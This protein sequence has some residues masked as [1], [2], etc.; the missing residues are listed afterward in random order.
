MHSYKSDHSK[1]YSGFKMAESWIQTTQFLNQWEI[2]A[3]LKENNKLLKYRHLWNIHAHS[4][5]R[6][7]TH[8]LTSLSVRLRL[9]KAIFRLRL[10]PQWQEQHFWG[11]WS[12]RANHS[13][14]KEKQVLALTPSP[15]FGDTLSCAQG[16]VL[17]RHVFHR[18]WSSA[19]L[20]TG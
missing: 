8:T 3:V 5:S 20:E 2:W 7:H 19:A 10:Q 13:T 1:I 4:H 6:T 17:Q 15:L 9:H 18:E 11:S 12:Q 16:R 14:S